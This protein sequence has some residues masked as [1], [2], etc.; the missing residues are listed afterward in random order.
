MGPP[1]LA[2][3][4]VIINR[5]RLNWVREH[6]EGFWDK[7]QSGE[8]EPQTYREIDRRVTA[9][10][11]FIDFG[12]NIGAITLYAARKAAQ[13]ICFE[14]DPLSRSMLLANIKVN[15]DVAGKISVV[16]KAV[17]SSG[18]PIQ[19]GSQNSGGDSMSSSILPNLKTVW[20]VETVTPDEVNSMLPAKN[21]PIFV[22]MDIEGGEYDVIPAARTLW[23]RSNLTLLVSTHQSVLERFMSRKAIKHLTREIF[24]ALR[25]YDVGQ[26]CTGGIKGGA[27]L[28]LLHRWG[29][30]APLGGQEWL[31]TRR[32]II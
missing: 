7:A 19:F 17:H 10:T 11:I 18:R 29:L 24:A 25:D 1:S 3:Q 30:A 31:F 32:N 16:P 2:P 4:S 6:Y 27:G 20:T 8:W 22:K 13:V 14:P 9:D 28:S 15:P 23:N 5:N 26:V 12:A 21:I